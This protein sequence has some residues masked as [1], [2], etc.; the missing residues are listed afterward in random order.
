M[1]CRGN[2]T[3]SSPCRQNLQSLTWTEIHNSFFLNEQGLLSCFVT[4]GE[5]V[6][7]LFKTQH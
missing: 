6:L 7:L 4:A 2:A 3:N 1:F 5:V